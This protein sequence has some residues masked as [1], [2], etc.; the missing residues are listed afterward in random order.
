MLLRCC[1]CPL[2]AVREGGTRVRK[3]LIS[4]RAPR[5][6]HG[7]RQSAIVITGL[8]SGTPGLGCLHECPCFRS[9]CESSPPHEVGSLVGVPHGM[10]VGFLPPVLIA[11]VALADSFP[12]G[13]IPSSTCVELGYTP[14]PGED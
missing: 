12:Q 13:F 5:N 1:L 7:D 10:G 9:R 14:G 4:G 11:R 2:V 8:P 3:V 6:K